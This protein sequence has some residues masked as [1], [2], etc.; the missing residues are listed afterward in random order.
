MQQ[1]A[2]AEKTRGDV[3]GNYNILIHPCPFPPAFLEYHFRKSYSFHQRPLLGKYRPLK[4][5]GRHPWES[6][7]HDSL[8]KVEVSF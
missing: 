3:Y 4:G 5:L 7:P 8:Q 6:C 1:K 2:D